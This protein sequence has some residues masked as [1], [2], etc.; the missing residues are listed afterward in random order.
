MQKVF[1]SIIIWLLE[2]YGDNETV[3]DGLNGNIGTFSWTGSPYPLYQSEKNCFLAL[4][5]NPDM[6]VKVKE[7]A[8]SHIKDL[9]ELMKQEQSRIDYERMHFQ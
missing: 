6:G 4:L 9:D 3:F 2:N 5:D 1:S 8:K 7:W